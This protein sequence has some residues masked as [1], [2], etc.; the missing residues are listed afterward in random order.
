VTADFGQNPPSLRHYAVHSLSFAF[1]DFCGMVTL[2][3][4]NKEYSSMIIHTRIKSEQVEIPYPWG[5]ANPCPVSFV[6]SGSQRIL[7]AFDLRKPLPDNRQRESRLDEP[8]V[9]GGAAVVQLI[10][11]L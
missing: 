3:W 11:T 10:P 2:R 5:K 6:C 7:L 4:F 8:C 9:G 1:S